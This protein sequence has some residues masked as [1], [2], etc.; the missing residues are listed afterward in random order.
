MT[1]RLFISS[2]E[3]PFQPVGVVAG[4]GGCPGD[5]ARQSGVPTVSGPGLDLVGAQLA[6]GARC[7]RSRAFTLVELLVV[8]A[9]IAILAALLLPA[10]NRAK[11]SA[12]RVKCA[13]NLQQIELATTLY[14]ADCGAYPFYWTD[15][16]QYNYSSGGDIWSAPLAGY[17]GSN[18]WWSGVYRC[19]G[20]PD[21]V[22]TSISISLNAHLNPPAGFSASL[23]PSSYGVNSQGTD[24]YTPQGL[25]GVFPDQG[26][27]LP[28]TIPPLR[29][30][31][32]LAP[33]DMIAFGDASIVQAYKGL[34]P[35][36][37]EGN[38]SG[39]LNFTEYPYL[40]S[41]APERRLSGLRIEAQR[42]HGLFNVAFCDA[43]V[44]A[45][46]PQ[47]L[48]GVAPDLTKRWNRDHQPHT[49]AW[50]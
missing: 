32:I 47:K 15:Y 38:W 27:P 17:A 2:R 25:C 29:E 28:Q 46:K 36:L 39:T 37:W 41:L 14:I 33:S 13:S 30:V 3:R 19:P 50:K 31:D 23:T 44:E 40:D 42:H 49:D 11:Q 16:G 18:V 10:L 22:W 7:S 1:S 20:T 48:F 4:L 24:I 34:P 5:H 45:P 9:I 35:Q 6:P 8:V 12:H 21:H 26:S 43:H